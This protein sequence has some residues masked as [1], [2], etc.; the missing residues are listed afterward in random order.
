[1]SLNSITEVC[2]RFGLSKDLTV[3][4][5]KESLK[6]IIVKNHPDATSGNFTSPEQEMTYHAAREAAK[7]V[8]ELDLAEQAPF[9]LSVPAGLSE[10]V[11]AAVEPFLQEQKAALVALQGVATVKAQEAA[12]E[13]KRE[14]V[15]TKIGRLEVGARKGVEVKLKEIRLQNYVP[16]I[17]FS[18]LAAGLTILWFL[19]QRIT[20]NQTLQQIVDVGNPAFVL[21]WLGSLL[22][23]GV[24]WL[25]SWYLEN[26]YRGRYT[27]LARNDYQEELF[28]RFIRFLDS[29][30][31]GVLPQQGFSKSD[32]TRFIYME[33]NPTKLFFFRSKSRF[34][35]DKIA[36]IKTS[37]GEARNRFNQRKSEELSNLTA[38]I[39]Q[40]SRERDMTGNPIR[41]EEE[42]KNALTSISVIHDEAEIYTLEMNRTL[43]DLF[44]DFKYAPMKSSLFP[45]VTQVFDP[46]IAEQLAE[47][48]LQ[49]ALLRG[50]LQQFSQRNSIDDWFTW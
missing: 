35:F 42:Y 14:S 9:S 31:P 41:R 17:T 28:S 16:K 1:V 33:L 24:I 47:I 22:L 8:D 11:K 32:L 36:I 39:E 37:Y 26:R 15:L 38:T 2:E 5:V 40:I 25:V 34:P 12:E 49:K 18:L 46:E 23:V 13:S 3:E 21:I 19:P 43:G 6:N 10:L 29:F 48:M 20:D 27:V 45:Q 4:E 50:N 7:Y 44:F 30:P